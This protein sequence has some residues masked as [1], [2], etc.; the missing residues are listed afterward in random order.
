M[1]SNNRGIRFLI[2][3]ISLVVLMPSAAQ[4]NRFADMLEQ[5]E[6]EATQ[7]EGQIADAKRKEQAKID[8]RNRELERQRKEREARIAKARA[9]NK[10]CDDWSERLDRE[11]AALVN[12]GNQ[13]DRNNAKIRDL[14]AR[15]KQAIQDRN[16]AQQRVNSACDPNFNHFCDVTRQMSGWNRE[17]PSKIDQA[18]DDLVWR[19]KNLVASHNDRLDRQRADIKKYNRECANGG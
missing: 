18:L 12:S 17:S 5:Q 1:F 11:E 7:V 2:L 6:Q 13:I 3:G 10:R 4:A 15:Y 9:H 19:N 16:A 14:N 8:E